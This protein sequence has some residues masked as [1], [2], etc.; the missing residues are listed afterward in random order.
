MPAIAIGR[1]A[2]FCHRH[3]QA[4]ISADASWDYFNLVCSVSL[5]TG[6]IGFEY[7][8]RKSRHD[9]KKDSVGFEWH[10]KL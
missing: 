7:V 10:P 6:L 9:L 8:W 2:L 1:V 5:A 4:W 3:R